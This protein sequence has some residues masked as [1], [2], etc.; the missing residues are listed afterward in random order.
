MFVILPLLALIL[1]TATIYRQH[2]NPRHALLAG[3][4]ILGIILTVF[5]EI[6]SLF[7]ALTPVALSIAWGG[8]LPD[9]GCSLI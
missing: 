1:L 8:C 6:L 4:V 2:N 7:N 3:T 9:R 5:T